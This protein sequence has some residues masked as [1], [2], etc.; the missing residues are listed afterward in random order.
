M[1]KKRLIFIWIKLVTSLEFIK[2]SILVTTIIND[3]IE[4]K[5]NFTWKMN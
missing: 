4:N 1:M 5:H 3:K 2:T